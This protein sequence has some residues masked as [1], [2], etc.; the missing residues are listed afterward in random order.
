MKLLLIFML[1]IGLSAAYESGTVSYV[2]DGD[3]F[4]VQFQNGTISRIR[5]A[6]INCPEMDTIQGQLAKNVT[7]AILQNK[8]V[9][10]DIDS[11]D[12]YNRLVC[13]VYLSGIEGQPLYNFNQILLDLGLA[14]ENN[15][16]N[17][18]EN[19][20]AICPES[21]YYYK[22]MDTGTLFYNIEVNFSQK[23]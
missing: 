1:G 7:W 20:S 8:T 2:V 15:H 21:W 23:K 19:L 12:R 17:K 18:W 16:P 4:D 9:W 10:L 22:I 11:P 3:T 13:V 14:K 5:L 6:D